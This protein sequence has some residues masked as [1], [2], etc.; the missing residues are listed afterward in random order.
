MACLDEWTGLLAV[1]SRT[2]CPRS[3][4]QRV[5]PGSGLSLHIPQLELSAPIRLCHFRPEPCHCTAKRSNRRRVVPALARPT[6]VI[7]YEE[8]AVNAA[9]LHYLSRRILLLL[10]AL[11]YLKPRRGGS[12]VGPFCGQHDTVNHDLPR[13][14]SV[15][16]VNCKHL[17]EH[18]K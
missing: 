18:H 2:G 5:S 13:R 17:I 11:L 7:G 12:F 9:R 8:L 14:N 3:K 4:A 15:A 10:P 1:L 6:G 16:F